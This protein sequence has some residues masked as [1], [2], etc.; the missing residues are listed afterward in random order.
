M[1]SKME[2]ALLIIVFLISQVYG[3]QNDSIT[4]T[5]NQTD[6]S[7]QALHSR[8]PGLNLVC[9]NKLYGLSP[10]CQFRRL[11]N[12][13]RC[14]CTLT[15]MPEFTCKYQTKINS[16]VIWEDHKPPSIDPLPCLVNMP[17]PTADYSIL[18][19]KWSQK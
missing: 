1:I 14:S 8:A 4:E 7:C 16:S 12:L 13:D 3:L 9:C 10:D 11:C 6:T 15:M 18:I 19:Q 5:T 17:N 2:L